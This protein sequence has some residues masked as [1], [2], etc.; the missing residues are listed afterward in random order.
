MRCA[1][2]GTSRSTAGCG[3]TPRAH[4]YVLRAA[5]D[6]APPAKSAGRTLAASPL[7]ASVVLAG[8]AVFLAGNATQRYFPIKSRRDVTR[9]DERRNVRILTPDRYTGLP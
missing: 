9:D 6:A 7:F 8:S 3:G 2:G 5:E 1:V 4:L